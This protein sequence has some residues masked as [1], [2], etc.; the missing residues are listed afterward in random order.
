MFKEKF[1]G[2]KNHITILLFFVNIL[3]FITFNSALAQNKYTLSGIIK[4]AETGEA[5]IGAN[6]LVKELKGVGSTTNAYGFYSLT[7]P[8]GK[9]TIQISYIGFKPRTDTISLNRNKTVNFVLNSESI[10]IGEV[11]VSGEKLNTNIISTEMS[12]NKLPVRELQS[13]PVLLGEKDILKTIQLLPGVK[14]AGEGN[15]G[16]FARGGR[17]DQ[18]LIMLDE[19]PV[20]NASHLLGFMSVFNS[21]AIKDVKMMT[22]SI[23][24]EYGGRLSSVLDL[25]MNDGNSKNFGF[26]G[27]I[28]LISSRLTVQGPI[29]KDEGSFIVSGRRTYADL[30]LKLSS[31][32]IIKQTSLYF[33]D[34][35]MKANYKFGEKDRVFL[36][37]YFGRD[38]FVYPDVIG[39]NWGNSTATLRWNHLFGDQFFSN[40]SLIYS[41]YSYTN[42][43]GA[44]T[45]QFS[46]KSGIHDLNFKTDFQYFISSFSTMKFGVNSIYHTFLP[47]TISAG[48]TS[49]VNSSTIDRKYALE[50]AAYFSHEYEVLPELKINY[51][52]RF[53]TF[54]LMGPGEFYSYDED[55]NTTSTKTYSSGRFV[56]TFIGLEPRVAANFLLDDMSSIKASYAR[57]TQYLH[58]L[59]NS[60]TTKPNDLWIPSSNN[61]EPQRG[62]QF[63]LGY[64]RNFNE[65]EYETSLE[66]Y[67]KDMRNLIDYKNDAD[68]ELNSRV[69][70]QLLFGRGWSYGAEFLVKKKFGKFTGWLGYT[71]ARTAEQFTKINNGKSFPARQDRTHD[72]SVVAMYNMSNRWNLSAT[73]VYNTG[74]A[75]TFP[76]GKYKIDGRI[77][78]SYTERNGYR[79]SAYHR[80]DFS[81]IYNISERSN[82]NLSVYNVYNQANPYAIFFR[83]NEND[84]DKT[85]AVKITLF[86]IIPS[87]TYNFNF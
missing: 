10:V 18:N 51:G 7:I 39:F 64:F 20:Y 38:N 49:S 11:V 1:H 26:S 75:V 80:L 36:S 3:I 27:G 22:G 14:S 34:I 30:F 2:N 72:I 48:S 46:I 31:D 78:P 86:P 23:P 45:D 61:I 67:Y 87:I 29:V 57:N 37:G 4:D 8:E 28:G 76:S 24:A 74:N 79:M 52:L 19:A 53:S 5:L 59:S 25:R 55:G 9:Y 71:L 56:K 43:F 16:F 50:N 32:S 60:T 85:E 33:Y 54:S 73:W 44:K 62:N 15:I 84:P 35:N 21:D 42:I 83:Q 13:I 70:S 82:L 66:I 17:T 58:L 47:G 12:T 40:T 65:N 77:V 41:D 81:V 63:T 69:E 68:L 6:I